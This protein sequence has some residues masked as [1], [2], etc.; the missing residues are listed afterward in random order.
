[1]FRVYFLHFQDIT[2]AASIKRLKHLDFCKSYHVNRGC[3][4]N[5]IAGGFSFNGAFNPGHIS[6]K[7]HNEHTGYLTL[8]SIQLC[9]MLIF[10]YKKIT[11]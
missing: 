10:F 7:L 1:M 3:N 4:E 11:E 2:N 8:K 9:A 6:V 5:W